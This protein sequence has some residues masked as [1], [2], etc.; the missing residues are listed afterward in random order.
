MLPAAVRGA[1]PGGA[2]MAGKQIW[3]RRVPNRMRVARAV[4]MGGAEDGGNRE[5]EF[6]VRSR[7]R[8]TPPPPSAPK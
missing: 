6:L 3:R 2:A 7:G 1:S 4:R 8:E 5:L